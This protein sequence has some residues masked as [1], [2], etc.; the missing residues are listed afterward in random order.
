MEYNILS[1]SKPN[2]G[3]ICK[4]ILTSNIQVL[5]DLGYKGEGMRCCVIDTGAYPH[6]FF[7]DNIVDGKNFTTEGT[8]DN[9]IDLQGHGTFCVGEIVQIAPKCEIVIAKALDKNGNGSMQNI[10]N[11]F[12]YAIEQNVHVISMSLGGTSKSEELHELIKKA[13]SLGI[14]VCTAGGNEGDGKENTNEYSYPASF[15]ESVNVGALNQDLSIAK[16]SNS[17]EWVDIVAVGTD[18][19]SCYL[20]NKWAKS[21]GTSM[22]CP[23]IGGTS[24]LLREKFIDKYGRNPSEEE[25]YA[26][27]IKHTKDLG[28]S[29][30]LQGE[31]FL[32]INE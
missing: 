23:I 2:D 27:L 28:M 30:K 24:L 11:A 32:Y 12:K 29:S 18:I 5:H 31:G 7:K 20:N 25:L 1:T 16:Y 4:G 26:R 8:P 21:S 13:N 6:S 22:A 14:L 15:Q 19:T 3:Y 10:I 9:Y 17:N